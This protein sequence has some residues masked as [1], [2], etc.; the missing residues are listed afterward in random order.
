MKKKE[1]NKIEK[2]IE[3]IAKRSIYAKKKILKGQQFTVDNI[4]FLR[5][6]IQY[7]KID[8]HRIY[9]LKAKK[10]FYKGELITWKKKF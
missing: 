9:S 8:K 6:Q 1:K 4:S 3:W 7:Q 10:G 5:P 2:N